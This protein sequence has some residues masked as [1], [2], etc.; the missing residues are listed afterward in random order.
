MRGERGVEEGRGGGAGA[1]HGLCGV[2]RGREGRDERLKSGNKCGAYVVQGV[3][4]EEGERRGAEEEVRELL[5][6]PV[7][8]EADV[9]VFLLDVAVYGWKCV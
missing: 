1:F 4:E 2:S 9:P 7:A 5:E 6:S 8:Q 3:R